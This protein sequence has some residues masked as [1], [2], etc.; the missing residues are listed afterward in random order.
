MPITPNGASDGPTARINRSFGPLVPA[1]PV[2]SP[3]ISVCAPVQAPVRIASIDEVDFRGEQGF[4]LQSGR[5][6][7]IWLREGTAR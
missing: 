4:V 6:S 1:P 3:T 7:I 2:P 5:T